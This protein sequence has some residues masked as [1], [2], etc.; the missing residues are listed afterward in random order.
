MLWDDIKKSIAQK[1][2]DF[3]SNPFMSSFIISWIILN[4]K[5]LLILFGNEKL[6]TKLRLL[7]SYFYHPKTIEILGFSIWKNEF[8]FPFIFALGYVF[9]Y[10]IAQ[11]IFDA[12]TVAFKMISTYIKDNISGID[13]KEKTIKEQLK[14]INT[15]KEEKEDLINEKRIIKEEQRTKI[16]EFEN[17]IK[18]LNNTIMEKIMEIDEKDTEIEQ[19]DIEIE[20]YKN[21][22]SNYLQMLKTQDET[23]NNLNSQIEN[24]INKQ[25]I[26]NVF[27]TDKNKELQRRIWNEMKATGITNHEEAYK[28][29][30]ESINQVDTSK[31]KTMKNEWL[32][33][34]LDNNLKAK[35][36][37]LK[38]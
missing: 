38:L 27:Q 13:T 8:F 26:D 19:K 18:E 20:K 33:L 30:L 28:A 5:Y 9:L 34:G 36:P 29:A 35:T 37:S 15:L 16:D 17:Q 14:E 31:E 7:N 23:V 3:Q 2:E 4:H 22:E 1:S 6:E 32:K 12:T 11:I 21:E 10:P 24:L 25:N